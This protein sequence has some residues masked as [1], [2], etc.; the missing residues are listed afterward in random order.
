MTHTLALPKTRFDVELEERLVDP[1]QDFADF[2]CVATAPFSCPA[3]GC[4]FV[5]VY[6]TAGHRIVV[7]PDLDDRWLLSHCAR[8]KRLDRNPRVIRYEASFGPAINYYEWV[9]LGTPVHALLS[10]PA[11]VMLP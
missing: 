9:A 8:A 2:W 11:D 7:W 10:N 1:D 3:D 4:D 6:L 5:A